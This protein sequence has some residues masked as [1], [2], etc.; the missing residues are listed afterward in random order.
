MQDKLMTASMEDYA[1]YLEKVYTR[2]SKYIPSNSTIVEVCTRHD[3]G[4]ISKKIIPHK[5]FILIDRDPKRPGRNLDALLDEL[6]PCTILISTAILH[7]TPF[8]QI[9]N[10]FKN[11]AKNTCEKML[12]TGPN[13][14]VVP[15]I[16][17]DHL[18]HLNERS[19][20][21]T[22]DKHGWACTIA[23]PIGFTVPLCELFIVFERKT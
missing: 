2:M 15:D 16:Y 1:F 12:F 9:D 23:E 7:H 3:R 19:L 8:Y 5:H 14:E 13:V 22:A 10:L 20:V 21:I 4:I 11:L 17:G 18:Y 6:P